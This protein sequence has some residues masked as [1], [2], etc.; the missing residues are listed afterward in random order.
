MQAQEH[1]QLEIARKIAIIAGSGR[2]PEQLALS[3]KKEGREVFIILIEGNYPKDSFLL[4]FPNA[5]VNIASIGKAFKILQKN[6]ISDVIFAGGIKRPSLLSLRPDLMAIKL[7][8]QIISL[9]NKGDDKVLSVV[10]NFFNDK[11]FNVVGIEDAAPQML[12]NKNCLTNEKPTVQDLSDIELGKQ[13]LSSLGDLDVGQSVIV[14]HNLVLGI[15]AVEGTDN[16]IKRCASLRI[17][18]KGGVLVKMRKFKQNS[19]IDLP[20]IGPDTIKNLHAAGLK[21]VA[22]EAGATILIDKELT[23]AAA[24]DLEIFVIGI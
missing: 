24:N 9:H 4:S 22:A 16:L 20:T 8:A 15:E 1:Q 11:G 17:E 21:G 2:L 14:E 19:L 3:L 10:V 23:I 13:I 7:L 18:N 6:N 5:A 12:L